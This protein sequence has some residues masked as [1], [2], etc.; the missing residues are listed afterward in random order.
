MRKKLPG[1]ISMY[2]GRLSF[3]LFTYHICNADFAQT[4]DWSAE[5]TLHDFAC[6]PGNR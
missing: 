6:D 4:L 5:I 2:L 1:G 3:F